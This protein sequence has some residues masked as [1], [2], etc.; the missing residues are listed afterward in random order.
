VRWVEITAV[1]RVPQET[2]LR[3]DVGDHRIALFRF[4]S[5][6]YALGDR[7]SHAEASLSEGDVFDD[8]VECPRHGSAF[9]LVTGEPRALPA[10]QPV[11]VYQTKVEDG[12][13][14]VELEDA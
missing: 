11:P 1:D 6:V 2:G 10:T 12:T 5:H 4:G 13:V 14:F 8:E 9:D 7:C 3:V